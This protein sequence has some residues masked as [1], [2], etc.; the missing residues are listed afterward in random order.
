[1]DTRSGIVSKEIQLNQVDFWFEEQS[2]SIEKVHNR[3][4]EWFV[5]A[6][7][8]DKSK[9]EAFEAVFYS[10]LT[11]QGQFGNFEHEN[12]RDTEAHES[13]DGAENVRDEVWNW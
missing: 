12:D 9:C 4:D 6:G 13:S 2:T 5:D 7:M 11:R 8:A 3:A 10:D 1:M